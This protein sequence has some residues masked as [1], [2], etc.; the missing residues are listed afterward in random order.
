M[1]IY[2][3]SPLAFQIQ[4][5][6]HKIDAFLQESLFQNRASPGKLHYCRIGPAIAVLARQLQGCAEQYASGR[7]NNF[8]ES[9]NFIFPKAAISFIVM[10]N[11]CITSTSP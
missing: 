5:Y 1:Q 7:S 9:V 6:K 3:F 11:I 4:A 10:V 2:I 8:D